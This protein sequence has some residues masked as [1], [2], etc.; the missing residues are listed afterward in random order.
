METLE[1]F[2]ETGMELMPAENFSQIMLL[3]K[4]EISDFAGGLVE[5][6]IHEGGDLLLLTAQSKK[7]VWFGTELER[8]SKKSAVPQLANC[9]KYAVTRAGVKLTLKSGSEG[10][11]DYTGDPVWRQMKAALTERETFLKGLPKTGMA[12]A[13]PETGEFYTPMPPTRKGGYGETIAAQI[14]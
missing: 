12:V 14:L 1:T 11:Y 7:I 6:V 5:H 10:Q 8:L 3:D 13:D 2:H 4:L 9:G